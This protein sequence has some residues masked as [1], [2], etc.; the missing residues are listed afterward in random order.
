M[1]KR[2]REGE[3]SGSCT[4]GSIRQLQEANRSAKQCRFE[5]RVGFRSR[6]S[7]R[8]IASER[9][10]CGFLYIPIDVKR[11]VYSARLGAWVENVVLDLSKGTGE[12]IDMWDRTRQTVLEQWGVS[13]GAQLATVGMIW[14]SPVCRTFS[15]ADAS[16]RL[17]G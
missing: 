4:I 5:G 13:L 12:L 16:N 3:R 14:M 9:S 2:G 7:E 10:R 15:N 17:K 1:G 11:W 8:A 6:D